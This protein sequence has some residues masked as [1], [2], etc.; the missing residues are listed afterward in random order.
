MTMRNAVSRILALAALTLA[1][2]AAS[3]GR[4]PHLLRVCA[5]PDAMPLSDS[6][7]QGFENKIAAV[8]A[9]DL[10]DSL[11]FV[12]WPNRRGFITHTLNVGRCDVVIAAP[13]GFDMVLPTKPYYR[14]TYYFVSRRDG[15]M[16]P[17]SLDDSVL[18]TAR[19]GVGMMGDEYAMTPPGQALAQRG[20]GPHLKGFLTY[21]DADIRPGDIVKAVEDGGVDVAVVWGPLAGYFAKNSSVPLDLTAL[22]DS[23]TVTGFPFAYD[24]VMGVRLTDRAFRD[25]LNMVLARRHGEIDAILK[26]YGVPLL[27]LK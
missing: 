19:I 22:P 25:T 10:G 9:K 13:K 6:S 24:V 7:R 20:L 23:D 14:A 1:A 3:S 12:W 8:I 11:T 26:D 16:H 5:D 18:K 2:T 27:P 4:P 15:R 17:T 21:Y